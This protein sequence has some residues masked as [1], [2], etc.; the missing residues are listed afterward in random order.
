MI[1]NDVL[2]QQTEWRKNGLAI[3]FAT[4]ANVEKVFE[5][6]KKLDIDY[7]TIAIE[8]FGLLAAIDDFTK[9]E[10]DR[11]KISK[12]IRGGKMII[13]TTGV[14]VVASSTFDENTFNPVGILPQYRGKGIFPALVPILLSI[15]KK[16]GVWKIQ[17]ISKQRDTVIEYLKRIAKDLE[18]SISI[19]NEKINKYVADVEFKSENLE[20]FNAKVISLLDRLGWKKAA[21]K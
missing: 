14:Y 11:N 21:R 3:K 13:A 7:S 9:K 20:N 5:C 16:K 8:G 15:S 2:D 1:G 10:V 17:I 19:E 4:E 12:E 6:F 18:L